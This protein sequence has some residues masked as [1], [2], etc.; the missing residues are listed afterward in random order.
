MTAILLLAAGESAR[1]G[2]SKQL[3]PVN[4]VPLLRIQAQCA[5][6]AA[7]G[8]VLVVVGARANEHRQALQGLPLNIV[9]HEQWRHGMGS[10]LKAGMRHLQQHNKALS[11]VVVMVSDQPHLTA[12]HLQVLWQQH[13]KFPDYIIASAYAQTVGVPALFPAVFFDPLLRLP[14]E[15]GARK[16]LQENLTLVVPVPFAGGELDLDTE[17]DVQRWRAN[18]L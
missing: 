15:A 10:S 4:G 12:Q 13:K 11:A 9:Q 7:V 2:Y 6:A 5:L 17:Y 16:L 1:L 8:E 3:L 14:D 18:K